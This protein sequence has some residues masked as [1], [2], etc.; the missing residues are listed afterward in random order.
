M[1]PT[2]LH[3]VSYL[4]LAFGLISAAVV[5]RDVYRRPQNMW[6]MNVV[7]PLT[8]LFG[9]GLLSWFYF[10]YGRA[11]GQAGQHHGY[12]SEQPFAIS[13]AKGTLHCGSGCTLGDIVGETLGTL[14]PVIAVWAG[15]Q[16]LLGE[17]IFAMWIVDFVLAFGFGIIFQYFSIAP[18]RGLGFGNGMIAATKADALSLTAWQV[19]MYGFMAVAHFWLFGT[20]LGVKLEPTRP[21]FWFMMQIAMLCGFITS[22]PMNWWLIRRGVKE[23]M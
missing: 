5:A 12:D 4:F 17:K 9:C 7:W 2:W 8:A 14:F 18:M 23:R 22:Y 6:I 20:I 15:W 1:I 10:R 11:P 3:I 21:E 16:L 13:V 19:G